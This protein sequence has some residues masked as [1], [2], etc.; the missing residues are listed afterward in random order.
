M[1]FFDNCKTEKETKTLFRKLVKIYHPQNETGSNEMFQKL[2]DEY[3]KK[4]SPN[5]SKSKSIESDIIIDIEVND[6]KEPSKSLFKGVSF[7]PKQKEEIGESAKNIGH[8]VIDA[9]I[10]GL[11][12]N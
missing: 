11:I 10:D 8:T 2:H 12:K 7:S 4:L 6:N 9:L 3:E 1:G 5:N